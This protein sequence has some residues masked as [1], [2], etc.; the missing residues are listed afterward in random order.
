MRTIAIADATDTELKVFA[1]NGGLTY[2]ANIGREALIKK[3]K[4]I[5]EGDAI[6]LEDL[7]A[8]AS[9]P[10]DKAKAAQAVT[11]GHVVSGQGNGWVWV[12]INTSERDGGDQPVDLYC[13]G[14]LVWV[15]RGKWCRIREGYASALKDAVEQKYNQYKDQETGLNKIDPTPRNSQRYPHAIWT[16]PGDPPKEEQYVPDETTGNASQARPAA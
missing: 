11:K 9:N 14:K 10:E 3:V 13:N 2:P 7:P 4:A 5:I 15:P 6:E 12:N 1:T 8:Q 16:A